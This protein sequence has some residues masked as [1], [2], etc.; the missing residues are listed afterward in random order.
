MGVRLEG[1]TGVGVC[2]GECGEHFFGG[3]IEALQGFVEGGR[4][5]R[6]HQAE[7]RMF[8]QTLLVAKSC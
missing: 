1:C 4:F 6:F 2:G 7:L 3:G 8:R 5:G